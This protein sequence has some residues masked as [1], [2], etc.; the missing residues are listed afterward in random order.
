YVTSHGLPIPIGRADQRPRARQT[1]GSSPPAGQGRFLEA[2]A[3]LTKSRAPRFSGAPRVGRQDRGREADV[4]S[5]IGRATVAQAGLT[6]ADRADAGHHLAFRQVPVPD[7]AL[8]PAAVFRSACLARKSATSA[9]IAW[10]SRAGA[11]LR[12]TSVSRSA[13]DPG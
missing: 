9:S 6:H 12:S 7:H 2:P 3:P 5:I 4:P 13:N 1:A 8:R 10:A 11:P